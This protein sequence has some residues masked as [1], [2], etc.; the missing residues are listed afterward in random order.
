MIAQSTTKMRKINTGALAL[1]LLLIPQ[2]ATKSFANTTTMK[3]LGN[4]IRFRHEGDLYYNAEIQHMAIELDIGEIEQDLNECIMHTKD[5]KFREADNGRDRWT[6]RF[7]PLQRSFNIS[8]HI[9]GEEVTRIY[10]EVAL[11]T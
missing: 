9:L 8:K 5:D 3:D 7:M 11:E 6:E 4:N 1:L 10:V 2:A